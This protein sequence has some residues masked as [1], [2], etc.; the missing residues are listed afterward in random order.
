MEQIMTV[1]QSIINLIGVLTG[2]WDGLIYTLILFIAIEFFTDV[3]IKSNMHNL[4]LKVLINKFIRITLIFFLVAMGYSLDLYILQSQ[5]LL[6][7]A[8]ILF[9]L[10]NEGLSILKKLETLGIPIPKKMKKFLDNL[11]DEE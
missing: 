1:L 5:E 10:S 9:Y 4:S 7:T 6:R 2:G 11:K 8:I 3:L